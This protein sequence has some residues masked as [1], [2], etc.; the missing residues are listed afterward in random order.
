MRLALCVR[1]DVER[2]F[3]LR[4][5]WRALGVLRGSRALRRRPTSSTVTPTP[6]EAA[7]SKPPRSDDARA[8]TSADASATPRDTREKRRPRGTTVHERAQRLAE[9][10]ALA[11]RA[12]QTR[13]VVIERPRG[14]IELALDDPA[15]TGQA[16]GLACALQALADP[17]RAVRI[18]PRWTLEGW[19]AIDLRLEARVRPLRLV[20]VLLVHEWRRRRALAVHERV[21]EAP[22]HAA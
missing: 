18:I 7:P 16:Y 14:W 1:G 12:L 13:A 17:E 6:P 19:L 20:R 11:L 9:Y 3:E 15:Q 4:F 22:L 5:R 8:T 10:A 2:G 21:R